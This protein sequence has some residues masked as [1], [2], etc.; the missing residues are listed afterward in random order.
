MRFAIGKWYVSGESRMG[1][2]GFAFSWSTQTY[3][4]YVCGWQLMFTGPVP[5][6]FFDES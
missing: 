3:H 5:D 4:I 2:V 1:R 6:E